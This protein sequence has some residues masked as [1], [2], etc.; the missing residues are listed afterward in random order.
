[1]EPTVKP[2]ERVQGNNFRFDSSSEAMIAIQEAGK[3]GGWNKEDIE[4]LQVK[5]TDM[6]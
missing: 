4:A 5:I 2:T 3:E 6:A 1:M